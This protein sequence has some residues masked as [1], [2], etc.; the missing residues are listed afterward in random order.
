MRTLAIA[1]V[2]GLLAIPMSASAATHAASKKSQH[3]ARSAKHAKAK[4]KKART[5]HAARS[6]KKSSSSPAHAS[7]EHKATAKHS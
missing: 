2:C 6:S 5:Q 7:R 3:H 4:S 1:L